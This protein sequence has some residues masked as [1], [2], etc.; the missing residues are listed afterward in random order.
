[1]PNNFK[2]VERNRHAIAHLVHS[3]VALAVRNAKI[4][5]GNQSSAARNGVTLDGGRDGSGEMKQAAA[6]L[7]ELANVLDQLRRRFGRVLLAGLDEFEIEAG[8]KKGAVASEY[9]R[10]GCATRKTGR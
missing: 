4:A 9:D 6:E 2:H 7:I 8:A 5:S 1:V 10:V 3:K